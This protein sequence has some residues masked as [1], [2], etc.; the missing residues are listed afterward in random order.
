MIKYHLSLLAFLV[1][2]SFDLY[3]SPK[4]DFELGVT[5]FKS[6]DNETAIEYF[7]SAMHQ[8]MNTVSLH[9]NLASSYYKVSRY[10]DAKKLFKLTVKIDAMR[11][12]SEYNLGL[13]ALKQKEWQLARDYFTSVVNSGRDKKLTNLSQQQLNLL[14]KGEKRTKITAF[15]NIGYDDNIVSAGSETALNQSDSFYDVFASVDYL[16]AGKRKDG[17]MADASIYMLDYSDFDY[18]NFDLF[19]LGVKK[20]FELSDWKTSFHLK[21]SKSLYGD[22]DYLTYSMVDIKGYKSLSSSNRIYLRYRYEDINSD[23]LFYDYLEGW[24]QR[25]TLEYRNA[26]TKNITQLFY[27]LELNNRDDLVSTSYSYEYSP[28]RN[29]IRGKLTHFLNDKWHLSGDLSYRYSDFPSSPTLDR[30]DKRWKLALVADYIID[31]SF[32]LSTKLQ[33]IDTSS[34][35]DRYEYDRSVMSVGLIKTF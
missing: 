5:A 3:A 33:H 7:E 13:V 10:E 17:W 6:G 4:S 12:L 16:I 22:E 1:L 35:E 20:S 28:T 30:E 14:T 9:Y 11:D 15:A 24:R 34:T 25:A 18:A 32:K 19:S 29:T 23:D 27:E 8:G 31:P 2:I 26:S 21:Y